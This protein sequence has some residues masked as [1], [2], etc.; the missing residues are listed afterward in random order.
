M[1]EEAFG[2]SRKPLIAECAMVGAS[3][4]TVSLGWWAQLQSSR[5]SLFQLL[6]RARLQPR[7]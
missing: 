4:R 3:D 2:A 7:P 1:A 5:Q 6:G